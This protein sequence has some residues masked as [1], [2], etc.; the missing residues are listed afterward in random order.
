MEQDWYLKQ[1]DH[2]AVLW[3]ERREQKLLVIILPSLVMPMFTVYLETDM[4]SV[5]LYSAREVCLCLC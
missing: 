5:I 1:N 4:S 2:H 3:S